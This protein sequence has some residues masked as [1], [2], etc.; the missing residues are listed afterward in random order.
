MGTPDGTEGLWRAKL[1]FVRNNCGGNSGMLVDA[2]KSADSD[3]MIV[4]DGRDTD[5]VW[6]IWS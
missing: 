1:V 4:F 2:V 6:V 5:M 3:A